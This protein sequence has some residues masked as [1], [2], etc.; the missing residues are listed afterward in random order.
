MEQLE[1][2]MDWIG[3]GLVKRGLISIELAEMKIC[4]KKLK[5][6]CLPK[7]LRSRIVYF[8]DKATLVFS[9]SDLFNI[10]KMGT[11]GKN[12]ANNADSSW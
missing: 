2:I 1:T 9:E 3:V 7:A 12:E 6:G 8:I 10:N 11:N 5:N 4:K